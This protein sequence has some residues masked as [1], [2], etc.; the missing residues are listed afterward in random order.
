VK[1]QLIEHMGIDRG[2]KPLQSSRSHLLSLL[3][4]SQ[5]E[6]PPRKMKVSQQDRQLEKLV[7]VML[8]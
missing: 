2:Y 4:D 7:A 1:Q 5:A 8:H 3:P 6:L